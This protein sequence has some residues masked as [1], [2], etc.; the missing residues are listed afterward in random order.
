MATLS[1]M[2]QFHFTMSLYGKTLYL[3]NGRPAEAMSLFIHLIWP[4]ILSP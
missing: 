2:L 1:L 3:V 4:L